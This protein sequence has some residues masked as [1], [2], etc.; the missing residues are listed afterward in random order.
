MRHFS[1]RPR[2]WRSVKA[3]LWLGADVLRAVDSPSASP[4]KADIPRREATEA[5]LAAAY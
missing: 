3:A 5:G 4:L 1:V 2:A